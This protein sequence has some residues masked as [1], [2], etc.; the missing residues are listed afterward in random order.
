MQACPGRH[1]WSQS[2]L[3][4]KFDVFRQTA[5]AVDSERYHPSLPLAF[6]IARV[7]PLQIEEIFEE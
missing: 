7:F 1:C 4:A 2:E 6:V 3:A 5:N